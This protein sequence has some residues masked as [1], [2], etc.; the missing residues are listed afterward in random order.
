METL[1][2]SLYPAIFRRKSTRNYAEGPIPDEKL[3][4][5]RAFLSQAVPLLPAERVAFEIQPHKGGAMKIAAYANHEAAA[6]LNLAFL[7][8][9]ADLFL[10]Q[11]GLGAL[12][13]A[14][15][16]A[17]KKECEGLDY[18]ISL[19][20]GT[21]KGSNARHSTEFTRKRR[22]EIAD[23]PE[24]PVVE[25]VRL[26]PSARNR[27]PW[28]LVCGESRIDFYCKKGGFLENTVLRGLNWID[29]GIAVCHAALAL[30]QGG[31]TPAAE[32]R[33]DAPDKDG[34]LYMLTLNY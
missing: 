17:S 11:G 32:I 12:W 24:H 7:L 26:A 19:L 3:A 30:Q 1:D 13:N 4:A 6:Y 23:K 20:F 5:L 8:Q 16:R 9:Q 29:M 18:V 31:H 2:Q 14:T 15:V 10:Q 33:Q 34:F 25:A 28:Y 21:A 22:E 27:Q